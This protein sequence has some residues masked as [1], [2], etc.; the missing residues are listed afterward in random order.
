MKNVDTRK[1]KKYLLNLLASRFSSAQIIPIA[2][3]CLILVGALLLT[4]PISTAPGNQTSFLTA[5]FTSTTSVCVTGSVVVETASHWSLFGKIVI[6]FLIQF[7]GLGIIAVLGLVVFLAGQEFSLGG[8]LLLKDAYNLNSAK[9]IGRFLGR[10]Y[11]GTLI[12]EFIGALGFMPAF[13][14][15]YGLLRGVWY[16]FFTSVSAFC[17]AGIDIMEPDSLVSYRSNPLVL[18]VTMTLIVL[19]GIGYVVWFDILSLRKKEFFRRAKIRTS[20]KRLSEHTRLII[21]L[22]AFYILIGAFFVFIFEYNNPGTLGPLPLRGKILN[23]FFESV[24]FRTAGFATFPQENMKETTSIIGIMLMFIGGSP[25]GTAGGVKTI[26]VFVLII[27]VLAFIRDKD[28]V[29]I[30]RRRIPDDVIRKAI[31]IIT[32]HFVIASVLCICLMATSTLPFIDAMFEIMSAVSTVGLSR[33]VTPELNTI[34]RCIVI[35]A[36]YLGRI[37]PISMLLFF[38]TGGTRNKGVRYAD[39]RFIVG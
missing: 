9:G 16:S 23:S 29:T 12:V 11:I 6:L 39:G 1:T 30:L 17:N 27:N 26:T 35:L 37:G 36:M 14:H 20:F 33:A 4:L 34:G 19:G 21:I 18:L 15:R 7:G 3:L 24:T 28:Q 13:I 2:F 22:T 32:V 5:L 31:A 25:V 38:N 8:S 10:V